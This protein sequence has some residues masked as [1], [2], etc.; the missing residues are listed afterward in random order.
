MIAGEKGCTYCKIFSRIF[1][2]RR[3]NFAFFHTLCWFSVIHYVFLSL[4][5]ISRKIRE[6]SRSSLKL[7]YELNHSLTAPL[8]VLTY[9]NENFNPTFDH[10]KFTQNYMFFDSKFTFLDVFF[11]LDMHHRTRK[12]GYARKVLLF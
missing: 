4:K 1:H 6:I 5:L 2:V 9:R 10:N 8:N 3:V 11:T 12:L 7:I